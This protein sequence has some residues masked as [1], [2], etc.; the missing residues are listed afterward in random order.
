MNFTKPLS[1]RGKEIQTDQKHVSVETGDQFFTWC[2]SQAGH[3]SPNND[4]NIYCLFRNF[5]SNLTE[6]MTSPKHTDSETIENNVGTV[7]T[8]NRAIVLESFSATIIIYSRGASCDKWIQFR[9]T[10]VIFWIFN[11]AILTVNITLGFYRMGN[12]RGVPLNWGGPI[13]WV[14]GLWEL[15]ESL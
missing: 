5:N 12:F 15:V 11:S 13:L 7:S 1:D 2:D 3:F 6:P 4:N 8:S 10:C 14:Y 9:G